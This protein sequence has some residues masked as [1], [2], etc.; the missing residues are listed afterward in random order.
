MFYDKNNNYELIDIE[1]EICSINI[2]IDDIDFLDSDYQIINY[3]EERLS[4]SD[5]K[6]YIQKY[7]NIK[8]T[9]S[10]KNMQIKELKT[11]I[12]YLNINGKNYSVKGNYYWASYFPNDCDFI[13]P[14]DRDGKIWF[15]EN[16]SIGFIGG[17]EIK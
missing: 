2:K 5:N 4:F 14:I 8:I 11:P 15:S 10:E 9:N 7:L 17:D 6:I 1:K 3:S 13:F 12:V 16:D